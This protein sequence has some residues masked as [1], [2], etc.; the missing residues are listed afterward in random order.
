[1]DAEQT[2]IRRALVQVARQLADRLPFVEVWQHV[3]LGE[4]THDLAQSHPFRCLPDVV[5]GELSTESS[6]NSTG[7]FTSLARSHSPR[8]LACGSWR[9]PAATPSPSMPRTTKFRARMA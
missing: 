2:G 5:H 3:T 1:G 9:V 6:S 4:V 8:P 7:T